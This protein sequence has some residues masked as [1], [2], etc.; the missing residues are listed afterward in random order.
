M[1]LFFLV[2][3]VRR[4]ASRQVQEWTTLTEKPFSVSVSPYIA[5][6]EAEKSEEDELNKRHHNITVNSTPK[7]RPGRP[8]GA[9]REVAGIRKSSKMGE[10]REI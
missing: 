2:L 9:K 1:L 8:K 4:L 7:A 3:G 5:C 10:G 6:V